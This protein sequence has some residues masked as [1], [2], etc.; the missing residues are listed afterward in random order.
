M[1]IAFVV[2]D[3]ATEE[4]WYDTTLLT[5]TAVQKGHEVYITGVGEL[6]YME[7]GHMGAMAIKISNSKFRNLDNYLKHIQSKEVEKI[8]VSTKELDVIFMRNNP[9]EDMGERAWAQTAGMV[10]GQIAVE[11]GVLVINDP[12]SLMTAFN[13]LYFQHFPEEVRPRTIITRNANEIKEFYKKEGEK[14]IVKPLHG[15]GGKDVFLIDNSTNINQI[16]ESINRYG[17]VIAQEYLP[18]AKDGDIRVILLNG[19][20]LSVKGKPAAMHRVN[21]KDDIRS[22]IH[23]GGKPIKAHMNDTIRKL[24]KIVAPKL[25]QDGMF[26]AGIDIVGDKIM[27]LNLDSPGG[28]VSIE[29]LEKEKFACAIIESIEKKFEYQSYYLGKLPNKYL[30][31]LDL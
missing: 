11:R 10:F 16:V 31:T 12:Y 17:H 7:D 14:I 6:N 2:N 20:I 18:A 25:I 8:L 24:C 27:E 13:K 23:A 26:M 29:R 21:Q 22:N 30:A 28:I 3:I 19:K 4:S 1:K 9:S 15:S 5:S